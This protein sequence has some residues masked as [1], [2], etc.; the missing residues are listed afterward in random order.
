M[1]AFGQKRSFKLPNNRYFEEL[2]NG[3]KQPFT[4]SSFSR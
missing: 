2:A 1:S 3:Q 4:V